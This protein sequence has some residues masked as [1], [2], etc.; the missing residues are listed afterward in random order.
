[1][2][3]DFGDRQ[4][5]HYRAEQS[6]KDNLPQ[7]PTLKDIL[8]A[9]IEAHGIS[10][11][12]FNRHLNTRQR[13]HV[14]IRQWFCWMAVRYFYTTSATGEL[15]GKDHSTVIYSAAKVEDLM[16]AYNSM[17]E[18]RTQIMQALRKNLTPKPLHHVSNLSVN[19]R[20]LL[21]GSGHVPCRSKRKSPSKLGGIY[22]LRW[23]KILAAG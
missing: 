23:S 18:T 6:R 9:V 3:K 22:R 10:M 13:D 21:G 11:I 14:A 4:R 8:K 16:T 2:K 5:R 1:M 15:I 19:Y 7:S 20:T 17:K 12:D